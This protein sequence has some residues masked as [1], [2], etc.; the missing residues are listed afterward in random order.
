[1]FFSLSYNSLEWI[2]G[3]VS[4]KIVDLHCDTIMR[5]YRGEHLD[6]LS[7]SHISMDKLIKGETLAQCFA[8]FVPTRGPADTPEKMAGSKAYFDAAWAAYRREL[9]LCSDRLAPALT[10][11]DMGR[12]ERAG[13]V[14]ALL[15]VED[16]VTLDGNL[17]ALDDY[18]Q[19]G[20]RM[21]ALTWNWENSLGYPQS[22]DPEKHRL[23]LKPFGLDCV[24]RMNELGIA[25]DVSHLSEGGFWDV[26]RT[27]IKPFIASHSCCR[28]LC[29]IGRNLTDDQIRAVA[30]AGGVI[31]LNYCNAFLHPTSRAFR[32]DA[33]AISELIRHLRHLVA[34]GGQE[35]VALGSD[36]DGIESAL[37]W[38]DCGGQQRF[39]EAIVRE[40]GEKTAEKITH[41]NALRALK[42]II[43]A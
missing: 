16:G 36:Y 7:G 32:D 37:E 42:D 17:E 35:A 34:V 20:V 3:V 18:Y 41:L 13:K 19:K 39:A 4:M 25:V 30:D 29:D 40:F 27:S 8:I 10:V 21:V 26:A 9:A 6:G 43:G 1:M 12:N 22:G 23:G 28:A 31:G 33:T 24:R 15:T 38:G 5:F 14:S 11:A 2:F